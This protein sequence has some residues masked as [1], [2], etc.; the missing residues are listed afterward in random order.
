MESDPKNTQKDLG[1][2]GED[3]QEELKFFL[4]N[5]LDGLLDEAE[6]FRSIKSSVRRKKPRFSGQESN[7]D[8]N[9]GFLPFLYSL[10]KPGEGNSPEPE[11]K[12]SGDE[13]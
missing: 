1:G 12:V 2:K 4:E 6:K 13:P 7:S 10:P 9:Q 11:S 5:R 3:L 8:K